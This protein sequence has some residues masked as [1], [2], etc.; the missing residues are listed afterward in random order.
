MAK[1]DLSFLWEAFALAAGVPPSTWQTDPVEPDENQ[2]PHRSGQQARIS[3]R[4]LINEE[5][6][7]DPDLL[8][9]AFEKFF[10]H[11]YV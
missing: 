6:A 5:S 8:A 11:S 2:F 3:T 9:G 10:E 1:I 7:G 4:K